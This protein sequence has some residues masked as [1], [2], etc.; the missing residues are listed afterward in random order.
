[1]E[2]TILLNLEHQTYAPKVNQH[3]GSINPARPSI[4]NEEEF[5]TPR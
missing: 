1:M 4:D 2:V 3:I 5:I